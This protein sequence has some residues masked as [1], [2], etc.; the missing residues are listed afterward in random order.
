MRLSD[1]KYQRVIYTARQS[2]LQHTCIVWI[3]F[4]EIWAGSPRL[5][6]TLISQMMWRHAVH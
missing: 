2:R 3:E 5:V 4:G 1:L 6:S